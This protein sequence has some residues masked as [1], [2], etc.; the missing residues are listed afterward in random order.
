MKHIGWCLDRMMEVING[1]PNSIDSQEDKEKS[2]GILRRV[3]EYED[4]LCKIIRNPDFRYQVT[5]IRR[6]FK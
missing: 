2:I 5:A 1:L 4:T 6:I 3:Q